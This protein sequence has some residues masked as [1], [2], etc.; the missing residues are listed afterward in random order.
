MSDNLKNQKI[1]RIGIDARFYGPIGKGLGRYTKEIVDKVISLDKNN[2]YII[3]LSRENFSDFN[4]ENKNVKKVLADVKWYTLAEQI[5]MPYYILKENLNLMHFPHFNV[6]IYCPVKF[7]VTIHDLIL[8]KYPSQRASTLSPMIY[9]I[10]DLAYR[11]IIKNA[12]KK[13]EKIIAISEFTKQ[14][15]VGYFKVD[16]NKI[17]VTYEGV[18]NDLLNNSETSETQAILNK[19]KLGKPYLLYVGNAYPHKNLEGLIDVIAKMNIANLYLVLVGKDDYFY[20][21][22]KEYAH[23]SGPINYN[24]IFPGFVPDEELSVLYKR[25]VAYIFPSLYEGFGLPPLEAMAHG[26]PVISSDR[27]SMPEIL[28]D[29]A[30]YFDPEDEYDMENKI[31]EIISDENLRRDLKIRGYEQFKKYCWEDCA[32]KT[33]E[34]YNK[35]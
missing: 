21:R 8:T 27:T 35:L 26:C 6:P 14:D 17:A 5:L 29:A 24:I 23:S 22:V 10:K 28:G 9:K 25:A 20:E 3:F 7:I 15:I 30:Y 32:N 33:M 19:Y 34:I 16:E 18:S 13:S 12:I 11:I 2:E 1:K 4:S 31:L